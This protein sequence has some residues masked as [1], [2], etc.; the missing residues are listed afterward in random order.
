MAIHVILCAEAVSLYVNQWIR[1][2][3]DITDGARAI[4]DLVRR[5]ELDQARARLPVERPYDSA[6]G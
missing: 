3:T 4:C 2:I 1:K 6:F 5:N